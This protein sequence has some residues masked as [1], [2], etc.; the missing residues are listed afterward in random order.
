MEF[1]KPIKLR[2]AEKLLNRK[3]RA[4]FFRERSQDEVAMRL[5]DLRAFRKKTQKDIAELTG[6]KQSAVSRIEQSDYAAWSFTTLL[7]L[8]EALNA[9]V[10]VSFELAEDF[11][12]RQKAIENPEDANKTVTYNQQA[13]DIALINVP[14]TINIPAQFTSGAEAEDTPH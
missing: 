10:N 8:A 5:R 2:I 12:A 1:I 14:G 9:K 3:Y 6:M 13:T 4:R 7:R 11:I